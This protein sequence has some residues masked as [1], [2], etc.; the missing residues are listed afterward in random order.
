[1]NATLEIAQLAARA[2]ASRNRYL[3]LLRA[4]SI[5]VVMEGH[6]LLAVVVLRGGQLDAATLLDVAPPSR[7]LTWLLQVM[8]VFFLVGGYVNAASWNSASGRGEQYA[9]WL[10]RRSA[11]LLRPAA[12]LLGVWVPVIAVLDG[13]GTDPE[14]LRRGGALVALPLWFLA[15]YVVV[16]AAVPVTLALHERFGINAFA[17]IVAAAAVVDLA[18]HVLGIPLIGWTNFAFVWL[19][20]H[21]LGYLWRDGTLTGRPRTAWLLL[22]GGL[23]ALVALV[24]PGP[25]PLSMVGTDTGAT[26]NSPPTIALIALGVWQTGLVLVLRAPAERWLRRPHLWRAVV[27]ANSV[28]MTL[29]LWHLTALILVVVGL[30]LT[31]VWP[32]VPALSG[33]WWALRPLWLVALTASVVPL[34]VVFSP[35]E[36]RAL[37]A[38]APRGT[39][40][41]ALLGVAGVSAGI[42]LLIR[43]S[44]MSAWFPAALFSTG[45]VLLGAFG[46]EGR[47]RA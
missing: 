31:G 11:R 46:L 33:A 47:R 25:Y 34:V 41:R 12:A 30:V 24:G 13:G 1:M 32:A 42:G 7:W 18:H 26:N 16:I 44:L 15:V 3:D 39:A 22:A 17:G 40:A 35:V 6:W 8:P 37:G 20:V 19:A 27:A 36:R 10:G 14:L 28:G 23:L 29:Y 38:A 43:G 45:C 2:P 5:F 9:Q 21:Q 4:L